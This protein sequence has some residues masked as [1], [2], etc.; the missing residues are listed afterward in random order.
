M[1]NEQK[2]QELGIAVIY[3]EEDFEDIAAG[4]FALRSMMN[5]NQFY[6]ENMAEDIRWGLMDNAKNCKVNGSLPYGYR[7]G[8]GGMVLQSVTERIKELE[9]KKQELL[10]SKKE[11]ESETMDLDRDTLVQ[12]MK[13]YQ[14]TDINDSIL[15]KRLLDTF[16]ICAYIHEDNTLE[17]AFSLTGKRKNITTSLKYFEERENKKVSYKPTTQGEKSLYKNIWWR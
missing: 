16:W 9:S 1:Q 6:S 2:L 4:R 11:A 10:A 17:I 3:T 5:V 7:K 13:I 8:E 14:K 12:T 15:L